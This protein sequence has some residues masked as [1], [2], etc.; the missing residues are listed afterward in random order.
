MLERLPQRYLNAQTARAITA[1]SAIVLG[2]VG[3]A[4]AI[5]ASAP[6]AAVIGAGALAW[7]VRV[8]IGLPRRPKGERIDEFTLSATWRKFVHQAQG[9]QRRFDQAVGKAKPGPLRDRLT[10]IGARIDAGVHECWRVAQQGH[11]LEGGLKT[12]SIEST[13]Q[14]LIDLERD[15][16]TN[17][18]PRLEQARESLR[19]QLHSA[20]RMIDAVQDA[21]T[22]LR[23]LDAR[24]DEAVTRA[25]E[26][27]LRTSGDA[28]V[29]GL[30]SDVDS[31]V[32][33]M[34]A[35]RAALEDVDTSS[36]EGPEATGTTST[37]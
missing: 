3:A 27:S 4:A 6:L 18:D 24:L 20:Q 15:M 14:E 21:R 19:A 16:R 29:A 36:G 28:D 23:L 7:A 8:A 35:L 9:A 5:L 10:E 37:S 17:Q 1:P 13:Q 33:D 22:Q 32:N 12:L 25:V 31:L 11:L 34:E 26:L 2:G 30:G